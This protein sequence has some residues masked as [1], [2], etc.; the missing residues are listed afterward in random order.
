MKKTNWQCDQC[1]LDVIILKP[2][3]MNLP[4]AECQNCNTKT[5]REVANVKPSIK[6][7]K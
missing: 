3:N 2:E 4:S 1:G 7:N 6:A 5:L